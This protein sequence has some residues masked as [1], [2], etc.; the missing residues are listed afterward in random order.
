ML[1]FAFIIALNLGLSSVIVLGLSYL[2]RIVFH[3]PEINKIPLLVPVL[4]G[5]HGLPREG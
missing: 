2:P 4:F 5:R 3:I 1:Y